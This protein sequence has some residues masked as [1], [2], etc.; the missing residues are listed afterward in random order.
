MLSS[1]RRS[2]RHSRSPTN[3]SG[4]STRSSPA[5]VGHAGARRRYRVRPRIDHCPHRAGHP[6]RHPGARAGR[7]GPLRSD[8]HR[9]A[10]SRDS[11]SHRRARRSR[12]RSTRGARAHPRDL[13]SR[14]RLRSPPRRRCCCSSTSSARTSKPRSSAP[15][16][17]CTSCSSSPKRR[18]PIAA[19]RCS[20]SRC[21][22]S[23]SASTP[24]R[25]TRSSSASGSKIQGRFDDVAFVDAPSQSTSTDRPSLHRRRRAL[26]PMVTD[27][28]NTASQSDVGTQALRARRC[29]SCS[30]AATR[31]IRSRSQSLPELCRRYGQ[32]ER[33]LFGFLTGSGATA[34]P[35]LLHGQATTPHRFRSI[36][37]PEVYDFF[38]QRRPDRQAP[39]SP[40]GPRSTCAFETLAPSTRAARR[41]EV[42]RGAEPDRHRR[43]AAGLAPAARRRAPRHGR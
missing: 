16:P 1:A 5:A 36:G 34:V 3:S 23:R 41:R 2:R 33:T 18:S 10:V 13:C 28:A 11:T 26:R 9:S 35:A 30:P 27:W 20:S 15:T 31:F 14:L 37:L 8:P 17:T 19:C 22:T 38:A 24:P 43:P 39:A 21:S 32:N 25:P 12:Q 4:T 7:Y 29:Q 40:D 6:H 42:G